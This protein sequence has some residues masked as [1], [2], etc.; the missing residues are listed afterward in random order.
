MTRKAYYDD[1]QGGYHATFFN[2]KALIITATI[3][4]TVFQKPTDENFD[5]AFWFLLMHEGGE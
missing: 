1:L 2:D 4:H 3:F 5:L